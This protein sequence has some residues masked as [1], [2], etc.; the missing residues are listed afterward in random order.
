M[1]FGY[2]GIDPQELALFS[3]GD[4]GHFIAERG[5]QVQFLNC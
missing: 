5:V 2:A 1:S 4:C 3:V